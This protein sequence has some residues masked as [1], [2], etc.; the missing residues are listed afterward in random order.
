[1]PSNTMPAN[2]DATAAIESLENLFKAKIKLQ[3][4]QAEA[5]P[6]QEMTGLLFGPEPLDEEQKTVL[7]N[8]L[9]SLRKL[10]DAHTAYSEAVHQ[11]ESA[12]TIVHQ[13]LGTSEP[14]PV[15]GKATQKA[16]E[17]QPT[18]AKKK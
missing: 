13:L 8:G 5:E 14:E 15:N 11:A 17:P 4:A 7:R 9:K 1:M 10:L 16:T 6:M 12:R 3:D 18:E 2:S